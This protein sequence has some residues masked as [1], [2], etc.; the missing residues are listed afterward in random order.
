VQLAWEPSF[1][2][3]AAEA[4]LSGVVDDLTHRGP[5]IVIHARVQLGE[6][7]EQIR[8]LDAA[9]A[10]VGVAVLTTVLLEQT[11]A[12]VV[13]VTGVAA[14]TQ[15]QLQAFHDAFAASIMF[16]LVGIFF[17]LRTHNQP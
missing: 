6:L 1:D 15:A 11:A 9:A 13:G 17:A 12:Y 2:V 4:Y 5:E 14:T 3:K 16:G 8:A 7:V 10:S